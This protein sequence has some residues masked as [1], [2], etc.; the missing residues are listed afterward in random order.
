MKKNLL[1]FLS[2]SLVS[3]AAF[4]QT[5]LT[6]DFNAGTLPVGWSQTTEAT[7]G[8]WL[9]DVSDDLSSATFVVPDNGTNVAATNDDG[10]NCDKSADRIILPSVDLSSAVTPFILFDQY[11]LGQTYQGDTESAS[12]EASIDG[13]VT[14]NIVSEITGNTINAFESRAYSLGTLTGESDVILSILYND[15]GGWL[16]GFAIDNLSVTEPP[17]GLD[18]SIENFSTSFY[19]DL[20]PAYVNAAAVK[21]GQEISFPFLIKSNF[22]DVVTSFDATI[23][24]TGGG[25]ITQTF[26]GLSLNWLET[27]Q[28]IFT[29]TL[30][31]NDGLN[32]YTI[33]I[34]NV[35]GTSDDNETNNDLASSSTAYTLNP[36]KKFVVEE[37]TGTWCGF[38]TRG[39]LMVDYMSET[40]PENFIG[41]AVHN[42]DPMTVAAYDNFMA[43]E[44][45]GYP[46]CLGDREGGEIDPAPIYSPSIYDRMLERAS[47]TPK[48]TIAM[49]AQMDAVTR[50]LVVNSTATYAVDL[51]GDYRINVVLTEDGL[52]GTSAAWEQ[53]NYYAGG[54]LG[55][56]G[57]YENEA[58]YIEGF[59]YNHV[60][61]ALLGGTE[62]INGSLPAAGTAGTDYSYEY[63]YTVPNTYNADNMKAI[64]MVINATTGEILNANSVEI[65]VVT[66]LTE[67]SL[68]ASLNIY[69]NPSNGRVIIDMNLDN[70]V[71]STVRVFNVLGDVVAIKSFGKL[72]AGLNSKSIDLSNLENGVYMI[73]VNAG[74]YTSTRRIT[75]NK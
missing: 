47:M 5:Y 38:C 58:D 14:W 30:I 3:G 17:Q 33:T 27:A 61:R 41:I 56:M 43:G 70:S 57:G 10:C 31:A 59:V 16:Y 22:A 4:S 39:A 50:N 45:S 71:N 74:D 21:V 11:Y 7:D 64:A 54:G 32:D 73:T 25:T 28:L 1:S 35:N 37:G 52:T 34:S 2:L 48:A 8:G 9:F 55:L 12:L 42:Q 29:N 23:T 15:G 13:G 36:D 6:E 46:S 20:I 18:L 63:T 51:S 60:G 67:N 44:I 40:F 19:F 75:L 53:T 69:P 49:T 24:A 72:N 68:E 26:D 65:D 62:G 66:G